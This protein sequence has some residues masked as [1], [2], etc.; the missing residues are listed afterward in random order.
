M[1]SASLCC[2]PGVLDDEDAIAAR[3]SPPELSVEFR[4]TIIRTGYTT[5]PLTATLERTDG[6]CGGSSGACGGGASAPAGAG[7]AAPPL[8]LSASF[9]AKML[10]TMTDLAQRLGPQRIGLAH[11][12]MQVRTPKARSRDFSAVL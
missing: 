2:A 11:L 3:T 9:G 4:G 8:S 1:V 6:A 10:I 7:S 12:V 5:P